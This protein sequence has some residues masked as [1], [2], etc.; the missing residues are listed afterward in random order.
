M[1]RYFFNLA[2]LLTGFVVSCALFIGGAV[3][4]EKSEQDVELQSSSFLGSYLAG[5]YASS[6]HDTIEA[7]RYMRRA[8][9][10]E[11]GNKGIL[12]QSFLLELMSGDWERT[13]ELGDKL[14]ALDKS[15]PFARLFRGV[16]EFK[17][18]DYT[19][20]DAH[21]KAGSDGPLGALIAN[22]A[23]A[24]SYS[25]QGDY[26]N[27]MK[28]LSEKSDT[29][30]VRDYQ[31]YHR[32]LIADVNGNVKD[33]QAAYIR[34][35]R[36]YH[37]MVRL[38][39]SYAQFLAKNGQRKA[40]L[41][42]LGQH[43]E[44]ARFKHPDLADIEARVVAKVP[45]V[46]YV[47]TS[48]EGL[49]EIF[50]SLGDRR[51]ENGGIDDGLIF[52]QLARFLRPGFTAADYS[53]AN[54]LYRSKKLDRTIVYLNMID[55]N[56]PIWQDAQILKA[57][58]LSDKGERKQAITFLESLVKKTEA[59]KEAEAADKVAAAEETAKSE[60]PKAGDVVDE[61]E[62]YI[63]KDG[64]NLWDI[65]KRE[66][67]NG[68]LF[69]ELYRLNPAIEEGSASLVVG[70]K[71]VLRAAGE[72][73]V[74]EKQKSENTSNGKV[75]NRLGDE[76][77]ISTFE[78]VISN[79][80]VSREI[81]LY[82]ALGKLYLDDKDFQN[83]ASNYTK[84][85]GFIKKPR[86]SDWF[87]FYG[88]GIS[89]ERMK[90]WEKAEKDFKQS[91]LLSPN[92]PDVLNYLGYSWVDQNLNLDAAMKL[93]RKAVKLKPDSGYYVD[94]LGWAHYRLGQYKDAVVFLEKAVLLRPDDAVINDHLGDA[95]WKVGRFD[96]ARY[97]WSQ[98]L[99]LEPTPELTKE[100]NEKILH[101]LTEKRQANAAVIDEKN[102]EK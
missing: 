64:D 100:V 23:K 86:G 61:D 81:N 57:Q 70:Q 21:F 56:Q 54:L 2:I 44:K 99:S 65:A 38:V 102:N 101:G 90:D 5:R 96:E 66:L 18:K 95:Y 26:D 17:N 85:I 27:A 11:P 14:I 68:Q 83:A 39:G 12:E 13:S 58:S 31:Q 87:Y 92:R 28:T 16:E 53:L 41:T 33:A 30:W 34:L 88:R 9:N 74:G 67:G 77:N 4:A 42:V 19:A 1:T 91:L 93:I 63:V 59:N 97:Q 24:W 75:T 29:D 35:Y 43:F 51:A 62:I 37:Q 69:T 20:A 82:N 10:Y 72:P 76:D 79:V 25:D 22:I 78:V 40:A 55:E 52:L 47:Q 6:K 7:A 84:A 32:A 15:H 46:S 94:S 48:Q 98:V 49:A 60:A 50:F 71:I 45:M 73:R 8:L 89:Y 80:N 36:K 3:F